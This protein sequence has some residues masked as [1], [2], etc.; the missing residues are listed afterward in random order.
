MDPVTA[1]GVAAAV[2]QFADAGKR[3]FSRA[4]EIAASS[5]HLTATE[6]DFTH[7]LDTLSKL[8]ERVRA[9]IYTFGEEVNDADLIGLLREVRTVPDEF[10]RLMQSLRLRGNGKASGVQAVASASLVAKEAKMAVQRLEVMRD[11]A[12]SFTLFSLW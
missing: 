2:L 11:R 6:A 12:I 3:L 4:R 7:G 10:P 8:A 5:E 1:I 9:I